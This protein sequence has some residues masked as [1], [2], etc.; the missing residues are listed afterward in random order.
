[1]HPIHVSGRICGWKTIMEMIILK[2]E[3]KC[4][5]CCE[6]P[7]WLGELLCESPVNGG[8]EG[9]DEEEWFI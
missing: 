1:M 4:P 9:T 6:Q 3:Y 7:A 8:L 2:K 5:D